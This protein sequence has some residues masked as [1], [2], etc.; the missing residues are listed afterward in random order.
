VA[1]LV[2][3]ALPFLVSFGSGRFDLPLT[4][5]AE[6]LGALAPSSA[7]SYRVLWLGDP[8]VLPIAGWS[9]SPGLEA[10]TSTNSLPGGAT[11]F[12]PPDSGASDILLADVQLALQ[13]RT[14]RLGQLLAPAGISTI[15]VINSS[16]PELSG[17]QSVPLHQ[18]PTTLI[19][20]LGR[21]TDLSLELR[22]ESVE[23]FAN[24]NFNGLVTQS[25]PGGTKPVVGG[26]TSPGPV[27]SGSTVVAGLA[28]ASA[29]NFDVNGEAAPRGTSFGWAPT[30]LVGNY[31]TA[32]TGQ[33]VLHR[34]PLNGL[35]A[36]LTLGI[37]AFVWMGFGWVHRFEWL[38][39]RRSRKT[40]VARH[41][42][43]DGNG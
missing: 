24:S 36:L 1:A 13:G 29:F 23:V 9:V 7:G 4:S 14:V 5:V 41:A 19:T 2:L 37:W 31:P 12:A 11:L 22:T 6:S 15:V 28:P 33:L 30:Y 42:R 27:S 10:A 17:V 25:T 32:P 18:A 43:R 8:S 16:A 38:F 35:L 34:L 3:A 21:Q 39:M 26:T 20:A 40:K